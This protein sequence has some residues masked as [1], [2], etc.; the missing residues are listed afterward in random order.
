MAKKIPPAPGSASK[1]AK[2][3]VDTAGSN[4]SGRRSSKASASKAS[5]SRRTPA[6]AVEDARP[7]R[8][9]LKNKAYLP[10]LSRLQI[11][12]VKLQEWIRH[13]SPTPDTSGHQ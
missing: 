2:S 7:E 8:L 3:V 12:L 1:R 13:E 9:P 11:E 5:G 4:G 10:E 6:V